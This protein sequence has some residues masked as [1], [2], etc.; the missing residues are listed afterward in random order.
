MENSEVLKVLHHLE[1]L[2][3]QDDRKAIYDLMTHDFKSRVGMDHYL[4]LEKY[5]LNFK[6]TPLPCA[7]IWSERWKNDAKSEAGVEIWPWELCKYI[8]CEGRGNVEAKWGTYLNSASIIQNIH[9]ILTNYSEYLLY[10]NILGYNY[11]NSPWYSRQ[12]LNN[13]EVENEE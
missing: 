11:G 7:Y 5:R 8:I 13:K 6:F 3:K 2:L 10:W 9:K 12:Y 4:R 1:D